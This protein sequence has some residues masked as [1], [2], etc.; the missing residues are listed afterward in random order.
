MI[1]MIR[2]LNSEH[3]AMP[4]PYSGIIPMKCTM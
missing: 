3:I 4:K 1:L 2:I